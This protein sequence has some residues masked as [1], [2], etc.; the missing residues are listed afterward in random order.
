MSDT[1]EI[2][3]SLDSEAAHAYERILNGLE[4]QHDQSVDADDHAERILRKYIA[5]EYRKLILNGDSTT[6]IR[7]LP[8][9]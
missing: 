2:T 1:L 3:V 5:D 8:E 7:Q 6:K 4:Q 9:E